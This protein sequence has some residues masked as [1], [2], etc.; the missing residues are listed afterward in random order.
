VSLARFS[1]EFALAL[2]RKPIP[3]ALR[4]SVTSVTLQSSLNAADRVEL[5]LANPGLRWLD[6]AP[7]RLDTEL[8]LDLGY[9][10][11]PLER[12]F[13]GVI[14][15]YTPSFPNGGMPTLTVSAQDRLH[16]LQQGTKER[17]FSIP[18]PK[19]GNTPLPDTVVAGAV[20]LENGLVPLLDPVGATISVVLGAAEF[21]SAGSAP[22]RQKLIRRQQGE[23]DFN[24]LKR[25][26]GQNGWD[27]HID[28]G[29]PLGGYT[30]SFF[31]PLGHLTPDVTLAY[32]RSLLDFSPRLSTV[33]QVVSVTVNVWVASL[34][35]KFAITL[36]FDWDR[37]AL[38]IDINPDVAPQ[39][40][41]A[42]A[43][44]VDKPVNIGSAPRVLVGELIPKLNGRL[45]AT[46]ST[47]G[48]PRI[49]PGAIVAVEGVG[50]EFGGFYRVTSA[51]HTLAGGAGY[52]TSFEARKEVWFGSIPAAKQGAV[53]IRV[54]APGIA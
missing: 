8:T 25:I 14:V 12:M 6:Y 49:R 30:L 26:A 23:S 19:I 44:Y 54:T 3:A 38:T 35:T 11:E 7:L 41:G 46:G 39:R 15:G 52:R 1:P 33:G 24:F 16:A 18:I 10:P 28:H 48:D 4:A 29:G 22:E 21:F 42:S 45:T 5:S 32:G 27:L 34:K 13:N 17:W 43:V 37:Q 9:A 53:P 51:T 31:S 2:A 40:K 20:A 50:V 47:V 36:G